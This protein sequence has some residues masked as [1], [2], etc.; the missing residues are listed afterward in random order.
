MN[1]ELNRFFSSIGF[2]SESFREA[3][4]KKVVLNKKEESFEVFITNPEVI[5][6]K[7]INKLLLCASGGI[8][9]EKKCKINLS[10]ELI[11]EDDVLN[12]IYYLLD[13]IIIQ[14]RVNNYIN[15]L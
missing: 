10:Y 3:Q 8:N 6:L 13:D 12:Y 1:S 5:D 2:T 11:T 7:E 14:K 9:G 4:I 15:N